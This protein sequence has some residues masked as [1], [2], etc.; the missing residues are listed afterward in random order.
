[1]PVEIRFF[2]KGTG[3]TSSTFPIQPDFSQNQPAASTLNTGSPRALLGRGKKD[4]PRQPPLGNG[5]IS[6]TVQ[7]IGSANERGPLLAM[8]KTEALSF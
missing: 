4:L 5:T 2:L 1:L 6:G 8:F 3:F 7:V